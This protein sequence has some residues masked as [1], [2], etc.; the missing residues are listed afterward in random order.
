MTE[1]S[2]VAK[3]KLLLCTWGF[4][5]RGVVNLGILACLNVVYDSFFVIIFLVWVLTVLVFILITLFLEY[6]HTQKIM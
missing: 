4:C 5:Y 6:M 1:R 2:Q 3:H